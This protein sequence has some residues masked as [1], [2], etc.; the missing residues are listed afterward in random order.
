[1]IEQNAIQILWEAG[2]IHLSAV[3]KAMDKLVK[4]GALLGRELDEANEQIKILIQA[5]DIVEAKILNKYTCDYCIY[6][7]DC[8]FSHM[9]PENNCEEFK[10]ENDG[11]VF[12][13]T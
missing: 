2:K 3:E 1:M 10:L 11:E 8:G 9:L 7:N 4:N 6:E 5:L 12:K 13:T